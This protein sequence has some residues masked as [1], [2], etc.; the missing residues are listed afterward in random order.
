MLFVD[1]DLAI[2]G[3]VARALER[4]GYRVW[5]AEH[6]AAAL[7]IFE[8]HCDEIDIVLTDGA[9]PVM[10]GI[11]LVREMR[12]LAPEIP[13]VTASGLDAAEQLA[14]VGVM[15]RHVVAKPYSV[16]VLLRVL[17]SALDERPS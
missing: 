6:G 15:T 3:V 4:F 12:A 16:D 9:M 11:S 8:A 1:D 14:L 13:I 7:E 5:T 2:R 17:R 10:D